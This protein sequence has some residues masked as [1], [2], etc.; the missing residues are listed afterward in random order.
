MDLWVSIEGGELLEQLS[1]SRTSVE[2]V[3]LFTFLL[4]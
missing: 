2:L 3:I 4:R 1:F